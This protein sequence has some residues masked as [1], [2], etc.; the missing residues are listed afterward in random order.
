VAPVMRLY[1][2]SGLFSRLGASSRRMAS[3]SNVGTID[4]WRTGG[5]LPVKIDGDSGERAHLV[6]EGA[7]VEEGG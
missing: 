2:G 1:S 4:L 3:E 5:S 6:V 7:S